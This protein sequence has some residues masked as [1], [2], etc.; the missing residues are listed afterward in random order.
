VLL[1]ET[2][3]Q[4]VLCPSL[5]PSEPRASPAKMTSRARS[6]TDPVL[7]AF[8]TGRL[9]SVVDLDVVDD[10]GRDTLSDHVPTQGKVE[11][12]TRVWSLPIEKTER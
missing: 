2:S 5:L 8:R 10:L 3:K 1:A 7:V 6:L 4:S 9:T 12:R 11:E